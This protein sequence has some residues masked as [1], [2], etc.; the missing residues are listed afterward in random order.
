MALVTFAG[1]A[2]GTATKRVAALSVA[3]LASGCSALIDSDGVRFGSPDPKAPA[4]HDAGPRAPTEDAGHSVAIAED[5]G[6]RPHAAKMDSG[7][8]PE[9]PPPADA[10]TNPD[11]PDSTTPPDPPPDAGS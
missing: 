7:A 8:E 3:L 5:G 9:P 11:P 10:S 4:S 1:A 2:R 6:T